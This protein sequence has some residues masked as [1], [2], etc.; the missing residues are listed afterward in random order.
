MESFDSVLQRVQ[1]EKSN[2]MGALNIFVFVSD[3]TEISK[4]KVSFLFKQ[5]YGH[6][7]VSVKT[8]T[9]FK[10]ISKRT[11]FGS[12]KKV[13]FWKK[14]LIRTLPGVIVE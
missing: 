2:A 3:S 13:L 7:P 4:K 1:T 11:K 14:F 5:K 10:K 6:Y 12:Y 8:S 9:M